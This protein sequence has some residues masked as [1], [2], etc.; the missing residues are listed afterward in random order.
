MFRK[1]S[2]GKNELLKHYT[3]IKAKVIDYKR[4]NKQ[5]KEHYKC[6]ESRNLQ[7]NKPAV[8][9]NNTV[10]KERKRIEIN[11]KLQILG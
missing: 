7:T 11:K 2:S 10:K 9:H 4:T 5:A 6:N 3:K 8:Q 1:V